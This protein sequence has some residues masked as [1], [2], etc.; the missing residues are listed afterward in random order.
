MSIV[1]FKKFSRFDYWD[2]CK[3]LW[4][5]VD[6]GIDEVEGAERRLAGIKTP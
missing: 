2:I 3:E 6:P 4:K 1:D 5:D